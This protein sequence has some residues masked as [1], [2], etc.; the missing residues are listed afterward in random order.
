MEIDTAMNSKGMA[1][2]L[3]ARDFSPY[4]AGR[5]LEDGEF[6]GTTFRQDYLVPALKNFECVEVVFD[7][8]T[9]FGSSFLEEAFGGLIRE[10]GMDKKS[11][12]DKLV[13][14]TAELELEDDVKQS[15]RYMADAASAKQ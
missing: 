10:E 5:Y 6:N 9:G 7:G 4:P 12:D 3:I 14:S 11:L 13:L 1:K 2:I 8:V 15:I